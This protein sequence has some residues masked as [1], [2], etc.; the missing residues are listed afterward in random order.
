MSHLPILC[1]RLPGTSDGWLVRL[2]TN[3]GLLEAAE[4][5][6]QD[7]PG[8]ASCCIASP[9]FEAAHDEI[10]LLLDPDPEDEVGHVHVPVPP[11][12]RIRRA[13]MDCS[14]HLRRLAANVQVEHA[15]DR[16][17]QLLLVGQSTGVLEALRRSAYQI[18]HL[19]VDEVRIVE[20][21]SHNHSKDL[22]ARLFDL[23]LREG[24][25]YPLAADAPQAAALRLQ[26][27]GC[28]R[29]PIVRVRDLAVKVNGVEIVN[30]PT[31]RL[32]PLRRGETVTAELTLAR[33]ASAV[34]NCWYGHLVR[35]EA[36]AAGLDGLDAARR[37]EL[38]E[39]LHTIEPAAFAK[40]RFTGAMVTQANATRLLSAQASFKANASDPDFLRMVPCFELCQFFIETNGE[41]R[42][43][44]A[45]EQM[46]AAVI[47]ELDTMT[48]QLL[49]ASHTE[50]RADRS[51]MPHEDV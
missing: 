47:H 8:V 17:T 45:F 43:T 25:E 29:D 9:H 15:T 32:F 30:R 36:E 4:P 14:N 42:G 11:I 16:V 46:V 23:V 19:C 5:F 48:N 50:D 31:A 21:T 13:F 10:H 6:L 49:H 44:R 51:I 22:A 33:S 41:V 35:Y 12:A 27:Q 39:R 26:V 38:V 7:Q 18:K 24:P 37:A 1:E 2:P 28:D 20:N 3:S 34:I 40:G